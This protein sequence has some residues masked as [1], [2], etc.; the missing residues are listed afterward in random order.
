MQGKLFKLLQ[1]SICLVALV[2]D[3]ILCSEKNA[4]FR[5]EMNGLSE[6]Y[7]ALCIHVQ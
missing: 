6:E 3:G 7:P 1:R 2:L 5:M 4:K